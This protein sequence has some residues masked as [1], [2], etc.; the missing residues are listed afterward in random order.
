MVHSD[1]ICNGVLE[2]GS[3]QKMLKPRKLNGALWRYLKRCFGSQ[4]CI[5]NVETK[6]AK[7]CIMALFETVFLKLELHRKC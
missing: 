5:E 3:A 7:W 1:A 4:N 2:V 6:E